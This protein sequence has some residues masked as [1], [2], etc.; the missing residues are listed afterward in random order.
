LWVVQPPGLIS[1]WRLPQSECQVIHLGCPALRKVGG[2]INAA[3][4]FGARDTQ[5]V[6]QNV[7]QLAADL[8][9]RSGGP[10]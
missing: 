6:G 3:G 10:H 5:P 1:A 9:S 8:G 7:R 4:R 2:L